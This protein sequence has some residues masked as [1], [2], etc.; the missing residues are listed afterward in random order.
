MTWSLR[1]S[2]E[3]AARRGPRLEGCTTACTTSSARWRHG[4][5]PRRHPGRH[6]QPSPRTRD[7]ASS[8]AS[9]TSTCRSRPATR[10][11]RRHR[12]TELLAAQ[13]DRP[14]D[15]RA[16]H[17]GAERRVR[18]AYPN[19]I[20]NIHH[21]FLP[22]FAGARPYHQAHE[23]G[24]K[25]IGA[26]AHYATPELDQGP[27]IEQDVAPSA[28]ATPSATS[29]ARAATSRASCWRAP[30]I[31]TC[32]TACSCTATRRSYSTDLRRSGECLGVALRV[33]KA[34][35]GVL[36]RR[37]YDAPPQFG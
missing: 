32:A 16:L 11:R 36:E 23:R 12:S 25:I 1:F 5:A 30:S 19:R 2:D 33:A 28:I 14:R 3:R 15:P 6:Q 21:S 8:S 13:R 4:R 18:R 37:G 7:R 27:I 10:R 24:V 31:C 26:T 17:A 35:A 20:I 9:L 29:C 34:R 22:A